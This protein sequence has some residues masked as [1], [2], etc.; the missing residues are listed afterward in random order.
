MRVADGR[1]DAAARCPPSS[2]MTAEQDERLR[3]AG[4]AAS[5]PPR[6]RTCSTCSPAALRAMKDGAD[7]RTQLEL[8]LVKAADPA[9]DPSA[10]ALLARLERLEGRAGRRAAA[11]GRAAPPATPAPAAGAPRPARSRAAPPCRRRPRRAAPPVAAATPLA[12]AR[13]QPR[14]RAAAT[15]LR[16]RP[17]HRHRRSRT[18]ADAAAVAAV[19]GRRAGDAPAVRRLA[20]AGVELDARGLRASSGPRC[21]SSS[22]ERRRPR[23]RPRRGA[24]PCQLDDGDADARLRR[25]RGVPQAQGRGPAEPRRRSAAPSAPSPARSLRLALRAARR[26]RS[27]TVEAE[28]PRLSE[29]EL[30]DRF[31]AGV[32][33]RPCSTTRRSRPDAQPPNLNK[34][35]EQAQKMQEE[36]AARRRSSR[37]R[38][39]RPPP[40]AAWSRSSS[41]ATAASSR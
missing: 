28:P 7:A 12:A 16:R 35:L 31:V 38:R 21:S 40:A 3:R 9:R 32:R 29:E 33:R 19:G 14:A 22:Q 8:A 37:R 25:V 10:K 24:R 13:P 18:E 15:A 1:A 11:P 6:S 23:R 5:G 2:P 30:I 39:S 36:M 41:P 26:T 17:R 27:S 34:M 4:A 20:S